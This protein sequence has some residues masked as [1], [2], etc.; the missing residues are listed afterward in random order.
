MNTPEEIERLLTAEAFAVRKHNQAP[1]ARKLIDARK[2]LL[3]RIEEIAATGEGEPIIAMERAL[4]ENDLLRYTRDEDTE[5][6]G[7]L[8]A[9]LHGFTAIEHKHCIIDDS[10]Q[11]QRVNKEFSFPKNRKQG[12][13]L[14]EARQAFSSHRARLGNYVKYRL[15]YTEKQV[16]RARRKAIGTAERDY[17]TRQAKALGIELSGTLKDN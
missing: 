16:V 13:P 4:V 8:N 11:Y 6:I 12:L 7:S 5:M 9:A 15:E 10:E 14:D 1:S 3:N 2:A 17:I